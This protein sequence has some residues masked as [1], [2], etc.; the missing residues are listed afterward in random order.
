MRLSWWIALSLLPVLMADIPSAG[1]GFM[2]GL[3]GILGGIASAIRG[4]FAIT[5]EQLLRLLTF[6]KD[7]ILRLSQQLVVGLFRLGRVVA[8]A[9]R[10]LATLAVRGVRDLATWAYHNIQ[11]LSAW[12]REKLGPVLR[13]IQTLKDR[14]H[15]IYR[16]FVK[17]VIDTIEFI[18][19][20]NRIL[21]VFH[22]DILSSL[23]RV[24]AQVEQRIEQP[25]LWVEKKLTEV[26]NW[27]N[28][29]VTLDGLLQRAT[30][31][32]SMSRYV[33]SWVAGFWNSQVDRSQL[34]GD[35]YSR[36]RIYPRDEVW[37][38][39][40]ELAL[41]FRG[42]GSRID[43]DVAELVPIWRQAAGID[44]PGPGEG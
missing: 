21:Q 26:Q 36:G 8:R 31:I 27:I 11:A 23:D 9:V 35:P 6:L 43:A 42:E 15:E 25:F 40:K 7:T 5:A 33:P 20:L 13:F 32:A 17:P 19:Q 37:A 18:R 24:L 30:L 16:R 12:L 2:E 39:G 3:L 1:G 22:I 14:L 4:W 34:A 29:I 10:A 41:F 38:P 28:R 44:P